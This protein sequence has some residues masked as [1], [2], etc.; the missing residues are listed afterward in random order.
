RVGAAELFVRNRLLQP[1]GRLAEL[2]TLQRIKQHPAHADDRH[3]AHP[4]VLLAAVVERAHA[5][6]DDE[7]LDVDARQAGEAAATLHGSAILAPIR[8]FTLKQ[9]EMLVDA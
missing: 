8:L 1:D 3:V 4:Q 7:V 6:L 5:R 9:A 2:E